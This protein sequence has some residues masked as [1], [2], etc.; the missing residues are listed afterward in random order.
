MPTAKLFSVRYFVGANRTGLFLN[1]S[2]ESLVNNPSC[3]RL[4]D[5]SIQMNSAFFSALYRDS[6]TTSRPETHIRIFFSKKFFQFSEATPH[7]EPDR[8]LI[9]KLCCFKL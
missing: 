1:I 8:R 3:S 2:G 5:E 4:G 7:K 9:K 6:M